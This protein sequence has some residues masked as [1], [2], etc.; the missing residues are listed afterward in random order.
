MCFCTWTDKILEIYRW[1]DSLIAITKPACTHTYTVAATAAE[2]ENGRLSHK[3]KH[4]QIEQNPK[5]DTQY[6]SLHSWITSDN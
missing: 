3:E 4:L 5:D 1:S 2:M 6:V